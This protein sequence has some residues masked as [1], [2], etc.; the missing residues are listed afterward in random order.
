VREIVEKDELHRTALFEVCD[1]AVS[2]FEVLT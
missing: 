2:A 1:K